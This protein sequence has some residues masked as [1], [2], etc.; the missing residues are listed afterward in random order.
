MTWLKHTYATQLPPNMYSVQAPIP[1]SSPEM[2]V[3]NEALADELG[4]AEHFRDKQ[5]A[6]AH[7]PHWCHPK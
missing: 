4:V 5:K 1:V 3:Y 6:L 2:V 7:L